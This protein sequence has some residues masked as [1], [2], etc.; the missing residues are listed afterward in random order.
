MLLTDLMLQT[1]GFEI[2]RASTGGIL[3]VLISE[4]VSIEGNGNIFKL[5]CSTKGSPDKIVAIKFL[6]V[7]NMVEVAA[8]RNF[9]LTD[10]DKFTIKQFKSQKE[11]LLWMTEE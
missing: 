4:L 11:G 5:I 8:R 6:S 2:E 7:D 1:I 9:G 10:Q 3:K